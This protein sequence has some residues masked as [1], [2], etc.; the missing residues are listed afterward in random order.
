MSTV[1]T[2]E[3]ATKAS[4]QVPVEV[5]ESE[6]EGKIPGRRCDVQKGSQQMTKQAPQQLAMMESSDMVD[7]SQRAGGSYKRR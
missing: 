5:E 6:G 3:L 7:F 2:N 1:Q 4:F